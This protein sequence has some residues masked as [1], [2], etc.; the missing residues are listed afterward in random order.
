MSREYQDPITAGP[1]AGASAIVASSTYFTTGFIF[2]QLLMVVLALGS[3]FFL[4]RK[5]I[6]AQAARRGAAGF[7]VGASPTGF[8]IL[9]SSSNANRGVLGGSLAGVGS[10]LANM[11]LST[12]M[13][14]TPTTTSAPP[15]LLSTARL[16]T[17]SSS[18]AVGVIVRNHA[19]VVGGGGMSTNHHQRSHSGASLLDLD[20]NS[21][22]VMSPSSAT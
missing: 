19:A 12:N 16:A 18:P 20:R 17:P 10:V 11:T 4:R 22:A 2:F 21:G 13:F 1:I 7:G 9:D 8:S 3:Y 15:P 14:S 6:Q 5:T